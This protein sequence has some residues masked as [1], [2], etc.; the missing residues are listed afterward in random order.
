MD[1]GCDVA[2]SIAEEVVYEEGSG[3]GGSLRIARFQRAGSL[4]A[5]SVIDSVH[6]GKPTLEVREAAIDPAQFDDAIDHGRVALVARPHV[7]PLK[8][9][10]DQGLGF[11]FTI[12]SKDFHLRMSIIDRDGDTTDRGFTGYESSLE[13]ER[14]LPLRL[15]TGP[16]QKLLSRASLSARPPT[17]EDRRFFTERFLLTF[18]GTPSWWVRERYVALAAKLG[19]TEVVPTLVRLANAKV[20]PSD[21]SVARTREAALDTI[22]TL[23]GFDPWLGP[24]G[25]RRDVEAAGIAAA[26]ACGSW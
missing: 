14:Y 23:T 1:F 6:Y 15:A 19:T 2:G 24:N 8:D 5:V 13:Q 16:I 22:A 4:I 26:A 17:D 3:H 9:G 11:S 7:I 25:Q 20:D 18:A 12:S 21:A 10:R